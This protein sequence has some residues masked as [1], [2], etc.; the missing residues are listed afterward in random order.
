MNFRSVEDAIKSEEN[1]LLSI[2]N[3]HLGSSN[4]NMCRLPW[5][6]N[7]KCRLKKLRKFPKINIVFQY[8]LKHIISLIK[9]A[10]HRHIHTYIHTCT[11]IVSEILT[12]SIK[13]KLCYI[14]SSYISH[15]SMKFV[16]PTF[17]G[18]PNIWTFFKWHYYGMIEECA[19]GKKDFVEI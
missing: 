15:K 3:V 1:L 6:D 9:F 8:E 11:Y 19:C 4:G 2:E 16:F 17:H 12:Y 5:Q 14:N 13:I 10:S 7:I 18:L